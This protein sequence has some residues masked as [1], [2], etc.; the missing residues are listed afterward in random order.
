MAKRFFNLE[1]E[2]KE[3]LKACDAKSIVNQTNIKTLND[4]VINRKTR[5]LN[6]T[7]LANSPIVLNNLVYWLDA[8][9]T[10]SYPTFGRTWRD[11]TERNLNTAISLDTPFDNLHKGRLY[12]QGTSGSTS[13]GK[14]ATFPR[15]TEL[16]LSTSFTISVWF[17]FTRVSPGFY[18]FLFACESYLNR[19]FRSGLQS[20]TNK[21]GFFSSQS[22]GNF[23]HITNYAATLNTIFNYTITFNVNTGVTYI[24][25][26]FDKQ[27]T[28]TFVS[29]NASDGFYYNY[30]GGGFKSDSYV[31]AIQMYNR[32]L[33]APEVLQNYNAMK[34][35]FGL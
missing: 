26:A 28:G 7:F 35:R 6:T 13:I 1:K 29:P 16:N 5:N 24:N 12:F 19:G 31:S 23:S 34:G 25:G 2:T 9:N 27:T 20:G 3:Y 15:W 14:I 21:I 18:D 11:L 22:G 33:T 17:S 4:F 10:E 30:V 8:S 32:A